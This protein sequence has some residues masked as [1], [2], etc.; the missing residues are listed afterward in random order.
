MLATLPPAAP[1][2]QFDAGQ[3]LIFLLRLAG[4]NMQLVP[5]QVDQRSNNIPK[6]RP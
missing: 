1:E 2:V 3:R 5:V 4:D 6:Q